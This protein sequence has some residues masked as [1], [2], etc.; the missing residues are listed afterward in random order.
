M[1]KKIILSAIISII[2]LLSSGVSLVSS[3][4][5]RTYFSMEIQHGKSHPNNNDTTPPVTNISLNGTLSENGIYSTEVEVSL[6]A[7]DDLSG[8]NV[9][10]YDLN[11]FGEKIYTEPFMVGDGYYNII[12]YWSVD[13]AGNVEKH[14]IIKFIVDLIPPH[15]DFNCKR[16]FNHSFK[17]NSYVD[18]CGTGV[19]KVEYYLGDEYLHTVYESQWNNY[20]W[21][22]NPSVPAGPYVVYGVAYDLADNTWKDESRIDVSRVKIFSYQWI[23]VLFPMLQRPLGWIN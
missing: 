7:T 20:E 6:N 1:G 3:L 18:D 14:K 13:N 22:W 4:P 9:T 15:I 11:G 17:F 10:Y 16:L 19:Y 23:L 5:S 2:L 8:V 21:I 12:V